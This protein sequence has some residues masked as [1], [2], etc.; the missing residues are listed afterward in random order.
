M[1]VMTR[2]KQDPEKRKEW[3]ARAQQKN[4][5]VPEFFEVFPTKVLLVCGIC[6]T[7]FLRPL[8]AKIDEP[9]FV[10]PNE[11]CLARNWVP[12]TFDMK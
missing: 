12:V 6:R 9:V 2:P 7:E 3:E 10:C 4:A 5:I 11:A 8:V 1:A